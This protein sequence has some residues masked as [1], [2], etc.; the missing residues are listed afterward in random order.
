M[1]LFYLKR[2][3]KL[4]YLKILNSKSL[5][6]KEIF[7]FKLFNYKKEINFYILKKNFLNNF[8]LIFKNINTKYFKDKIIYSFFFK[9]KNFF[10]L[11]IFQILKR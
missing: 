11:K 7:F 8:F 9:N 10:F 3:N 1:N 6:F 2:L 5:Y 4:F